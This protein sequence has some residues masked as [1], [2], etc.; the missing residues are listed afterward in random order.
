MFFVVQAVVLDIPNVYK[1]EV[2]GCWYSS[3]TYAHVN[4]G[5]VFNLTSSLFINKE[6][7]AVLDGKSSQDTALHTEALQTWSK[8]LPHILQSEK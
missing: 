4:S 8:L 6:L 3:L 1:R 5:Q 7:C 2:L